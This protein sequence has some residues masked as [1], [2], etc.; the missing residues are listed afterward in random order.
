MK[1][2][3]LA[4]G[5]T[6]LLGLGSQSCTEL[7]DR[8]YHN[9]LADGFQ[10]APDDAG[11]ILSAA[12]V[13]WRQTMLLWNGVV[14]AQELGADQDVLPARPNGW[15]D[16]GVYKRMHQ[17]AWTSDEEVVRES[18]GRTF[19]GINTCNRVLYQIESGQ[20]DFGDKQNSVI[21]ELKVLRASYY[22]ILVD[23]FGNVPII[24][25][26]DVP[27]GFLPEQS[28]RKEVYEFI[29]KEI[30]DNIGNLVEDVNTEYYGRF[31]KWA[32]YSLLAKMYLNAEV[33]SDGNYT[34]WQACI[35]ACDE[36]IEAG[37][38]ELE[39]EQRLVFITKNEN[40][41]EIIFALPFDETYVTDWNAFDFHMY[42]LQPS[43]QATY[44]F[45][46]SPWG[47]VCC[48]PQFIDSFDPDDERLKT[49][50]IRGQQY[51]M[52]GNPLYC[53]MGTS[54]GKPLDYINEVPNIDSSEEYHGIRWG[55]FEYAVGITN[56]LSNDF[57]IFRYA[58]I[59]MMKA[60]ALLRLG[61]A[62]L[63]ADLVT[64]VRER[65]FTDN[66]DKA[67]VTGD[68]LKAPTCYDYGRRDTYE[69]T[70]QDASF[71]E[72]GRFLDELGW[73]FTQEGRRRQ[74]MIRFG[75]Y[76]TLTWFSHDASDETKNLFPIPKN[77]M[78]TNPNLEQ[79][80]GY[81]KD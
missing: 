35:D 53:T 39:A 75:A 27:E 62:D 59:L 66:P 10:P 61:K 12:Y 5:L 71:I 42:T 80:P 19:T 54:A 60:E 41:K 4:L 32:A 44:G 63:A 47:G 40:S 43:N 29:I 30:K 65:N 78:L 36:V 25:Q 2:K 48:T 9:I 8:S 50:F 57:P 7:E 24:T 22:Y 1:T 34:E 72:Y 77:Q 13:P 3:I 11:A 14:R 38:Y 28:T 73:E 21:S 56:R 52:S 23:L 46:D 64:E 74:D 49:S 6:A 31:N 18:W 17:H 79:N 67:V 81:P 68:D 70:D 16:G 51:D 26:F 76:T 69:T 58:D 55:K 33:F 45:T 15:V 37:K 20:L